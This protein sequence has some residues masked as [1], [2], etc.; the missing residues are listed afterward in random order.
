MSFGG[1]GCW[2]PGAHLREIETPD[3]IAM[4]KRP[5]VVVVDAARFP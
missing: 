4:L 2:P 3:L 1:Y 5:N